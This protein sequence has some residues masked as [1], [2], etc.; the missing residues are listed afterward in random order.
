M[1]LRP[2]DDAVLDDARELYLSAFPDDE[3]IPFDT[4]LRMTG[5]PG[6][7][8]LWM[9][10]DGRFSG[11]AYTV[12]TDDLVFL[13]Y[14]A[15][16]PGARCGGLGSDALWLVKCGCRGRRL[17]LNVEPVDEPADNMGQRLRRTR[18]YERNGF[19][20]GCT[21]R[22][23]DG[24]RYTMMTWGGPVSAEEALSMFASKFP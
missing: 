22:T 12:E 8:F 7:R 17:F 18:F 5:D 21:Y 2:V 15:V 11:I 10:V 13:L 19:A 3:R 24:M 1:E 20:P 16:S 23:P 9:S 4:L 6:C 14:L